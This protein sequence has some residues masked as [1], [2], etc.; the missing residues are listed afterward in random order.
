[1]LC[2]LIVVIAIFLGAVV[3]TLFSDQREIKEMEKVEGVSNV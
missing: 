2:I 3:G 1:M